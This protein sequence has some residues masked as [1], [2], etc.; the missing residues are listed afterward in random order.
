MSI[1]RSDVNVEFCIVSST[2]PLG[3]GAVLEDLFMKTLVGHS[4]V[5]M[6]H[7]RL[8]FRNSLWGMGYVMLCYVTFCFFDA[9]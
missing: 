9:L 1:H 8:P 5:A 3:V 6:P 2:S 4:W 7:D